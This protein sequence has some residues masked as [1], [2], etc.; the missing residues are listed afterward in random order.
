MVVGEK[1]TVR[2]FITQY[3]FI[4]GRTLD[5]IGRSIGYDRGRFLRGATFAILDRLPT[6]DEFDL[7]GYS[8]IADHRHVAPSGVDPAVLRRMAVANWSLFGVNRLVK[9]FPTIPHDDARDTDSQYPP[10]LGVPQWRIKK[11]RPI[12]AT[13]VAVLN[14]PGDVFRL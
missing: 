8:Q 12:P 14:L 2:G 10:G 3:K 4:A 9:V 7:R 13:V 1:I 11:D 6:V 5:E